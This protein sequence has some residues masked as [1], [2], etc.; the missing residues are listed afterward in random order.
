M[1]F[2]IVKLLKKTDLDA[3]RVVRTCGYQR[4][5]KE[6]YSVDNDHH[7]ESVCQCFEDGCNTAPISQSIFSLLSTL[8]MASTI[9]FIA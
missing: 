6:C 8:V 1:H 3:S 7:M 5:Q 9:Y 2:F 4:S